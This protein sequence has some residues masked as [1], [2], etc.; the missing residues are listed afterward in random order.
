ME[1]VMSEPG[2]EPIT[3]EIA[4][5]EPERQWLL[6][7]EL[8]AQATVGAAIEEFRARLPALAL[9]PVLK[10]GIF[11]ELV[12]QSRR[13]VTGDRIEIYRPLREDPRDTRRR[14]ARSGGTMG[15][16]R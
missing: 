14:I 7:L 3:V 6:T 16:P 8:P 13:L 1:P 12:P 15:R 9:P 4:Y 11:G 2:S 10:V 5:A